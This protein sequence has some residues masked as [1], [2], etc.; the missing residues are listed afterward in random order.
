MTV[1]GLSNSTLLY[2]C[3][4]EALVAVKGHCDH[5]NSFK[6]KHLIGTGLRK[7]KGLVQRFS[8]LLSWQ[9]TWQ[10]AG[11]H[12]VGEV[13]QRSTSRLAGSRRR[14]TLIGPALAF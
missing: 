12:G 1:W 3:L 4:S 10:S 6:G 9:E 5:G 11:R 13:A 8:S 7:F 14:A 2:H